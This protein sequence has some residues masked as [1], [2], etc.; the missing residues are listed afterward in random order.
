LSDVINP[1]NT[2]SVTAVLTQSTTA[3]G[4]GFPL[5]G[6]VTTTG[7]CNTSFTVTGAYSLVE[8]QYF[9]V[10][11]YPGFLGLLNSTATTLTDVALEDSSPFNPNSPCSAPYTGTLTLQ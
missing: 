7:A 11:G 10:P 6:T 3:D 9:Q 8:G 5:T 4:I 1:A 2:I